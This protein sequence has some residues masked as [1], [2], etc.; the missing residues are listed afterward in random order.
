MRPKVI[1]YTIRMSNKYYRDIE[2]R[3]KRVN[4][5]LNISNIETK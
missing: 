3:E 5:F 2:H 1:L 4:I